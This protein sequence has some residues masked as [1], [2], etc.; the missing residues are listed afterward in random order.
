LLLEA[1]G[2]ADPEKG[3]GTF[4]RSTLRPV[5]AKVPDPFS[6]SET[7]SEDQ[8]MFAMLQIP[9]GVIIAFIALVVGVPLVLNVI[10]AALGARGAASPGRRWQAIAGGLAAG[11]VVTLLAGYLLQSLG[12]VLLSAPLIGLGANFAVARAC[13]SASHEVRP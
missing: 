2:K 10:A 7:N 8:V 4:V 11:I 13:V 9:T 5:P 1:C 12:A 6:G 3:S